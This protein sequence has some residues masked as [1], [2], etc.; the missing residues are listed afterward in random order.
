VVETLEGRALLS[1]LTTT[2]YPVPTPN[3][4]PF[5]ITTGPDGNLWFTEYYAGKVTSF[6]PNTG[7]FTEATPPTN[8]GPEGITTGPDGNLWFAEFHKIGQIDPA[9]GNLTEFSL[10]QESIRLRPVGI[11]AG[12]PG[13]QH[14]WFTENSGIGEITTDGIV[15]E[16]DSPTFARPVDITVGSDGNLWFTEPY[17]NQ[18]GSI[19]T[20]GVITEYP[21]PTPDSGATGITAGPDGNLWFTEPYA[22]Q[23]GSIDPSTGLITEYPVPTPNAGPFEITAG[24]DGNLWFTEQSAVTLQ[25]GSITT[26]GDITEYTLSTLPPGQPSWITT[27]PDGNLWVTETNSNTI[28]QV[29][30]P[31]LTCAPGPAVTAPRP[32]APWSPSSDTTSRIAGGTGNATSPVTSAVAD[33]GGSDAAGTGVIIVVIPDL[34]PPATVDDSGSSLLTAK[35]HSVARQ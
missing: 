28:A 31:T 29:S 15:T 7:L 13:D 14:V 17:A 6:D 9:T 24:P 2:E 32:A 19:T 20:D 18:I 11:T 12:P 3:S 35:R 25:L 23:I 30:L 4:G 1:S 21:I 16:F 26:S 33:R 27:G 34:G 10:I 8:D 22:N 5:A